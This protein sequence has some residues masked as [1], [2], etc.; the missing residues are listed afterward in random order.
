[1]STRKTGLLNAGR[2]RQGPVNK[3]A[4]YGGASVCDVV[5]SVEEKKQGI[6]T[7]SDKIVLKTCEIEF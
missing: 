2:D 1:M 3:M 6:R 7:L 5:F 4:P